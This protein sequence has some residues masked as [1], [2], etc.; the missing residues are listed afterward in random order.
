MFGYAGSLLQF[1]VSVA[2][3]RLSLAAV[4]GLLIVVASLTVKCGL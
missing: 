4:C 3:G 2:A 1:F